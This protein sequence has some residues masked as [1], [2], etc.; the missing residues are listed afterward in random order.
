[1][2]QTRQFAL[3]VVS[4]I[5]VLVLATASTQADGDQNPTQTKE[6]ELIA[7][8][9]SD[10]PKGEKAI[11]CKHLAVYGSSD[12]VPELARLLS[13]EQLASWARISLEA[14]PG[15]EADEALRKALDSLHGR[16]LVGA[17]N[18]IG[19]RR[20]A[21]AV[22]PLSGRLRDPDTEI[23]SAAAAALGR[24]GDAAA[25]K[26]LRNVLAVGPIK[27]RSA[28]AEGLVLCAER[29][30]SQDQMA[31]AIEIY[32]EIR[33]ADVPK[34]RVLEATRGAILA[35]KDEGIA[36]LLEQFQSSDQE[37]FQI[38]LSTFREFPG[39]KVDEA[40]AAEMARATPDRAVLAIQA[41][42]DRKETVVLSA[43]LNAAKSG[44]KPV[45][46]A[47]IGALGRVGDASCLA[48]LLEIAL[49]SD[50]ELTRTA[51]EALAILPGEK[52]N[53]DIT[54]R[55]PQA[56]GKMYLL[57]IELV[58]TRRIE[59]TADLVKAL[60]HSDPAVR[61]A[62]LTSLGSTVPP[63][64][65]SVLVT[66]AVAPKHAE[67]ASVAEQAL[68]TACVRMPDREACAAEL[69]KAMDQSSVSTKIALLKILG[70]VGGTKALAAVGKAA[71]SSDPQLQDTSSRLLGEWMTI[72]AAPVL[73][74]LAKAGP[75]NKYHVRAL[76][77]YIRIARQFTMPDEQRLE[78]CQ[79]SL[80]A[81]RQPAER[82]LVLDVAKRYPNLE[83]LKL[84]A[85]LTRDDSEL[86]EEATQATLAIAQKLGS[87]KAAVSEILSNA[88]L[89][90][91]K[92]EIV[93]AEYGAGDKQ[94]DVTEALQKQAADL[95][96]IVLPSPD[97]NATFGGDP[98][99]G[100]TKQLKVQY[101]IN[102]K[103]GEA[104]F[105]E[106]ALL[107]LPMPK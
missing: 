14:I 45:R 32:D 84:A 102:G 66:Q 47:A 56:Q 92:V 15:P 21:S 50:A 77:G 54:T 19:V 63:Q 38:A 93:K 52:V 27:V 11:A 61:S 75:D 90:K 4:F 31:Q 60:E 81:A 94:K 65:L 3:S 67:D 104:S 55:L 6:A 16:L 87:E 13:D 28:V 9:R 43:V 103:V 68:R 40:L 44:P 105:A 17:I 72:D 107:I 51:T 25:A 35:R 42:A 69:A 53:Q 5:A 73:L 70:E 96:L 82:K 106:N 91:V 89:G 83:T 8:L 71:K 98:A 39:S 1:M 41:M 48:S 33:K 29:S 2:H 34:Q 64:S 78:M 85:K 12:A 57:L 22:E 101:R 100:G 76:R 18:S 74:D 95:Q 26:S 36:L 62:A 58:G 46:M 10:A 49:E 59:A 80:E 24:I 20:N 30:M 88:K 23:A 79:K 37:L 86:N 7:I 99:P 97:Y